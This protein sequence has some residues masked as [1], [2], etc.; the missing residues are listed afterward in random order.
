MSRDQLEAES[1]RY[2]STHCRLLIQ[3]TSGNLA[4]LGDNRRV[5]AIVP[6]LAEAFAFP[7]YPPLAPRLRTHDPRPTTLPLNFEGL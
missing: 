2:S 1:W 6:N 5:V 7:A 3:L 4:V